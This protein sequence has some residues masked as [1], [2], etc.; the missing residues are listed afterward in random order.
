MGDRDVNKVDVEARAKI[1]EFVRRQLLAIVCY[2]EIRYSKSAKDVT[3]NKTFHISGG[4]G[5]NWLSL[6]PFYEVIVGDQEEFLL[7][8]CHRERT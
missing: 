1:M 8:S 7:G 2:N 3:L 6:N 4:D 5:G